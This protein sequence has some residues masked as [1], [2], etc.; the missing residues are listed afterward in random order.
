[1]LRNRKERR[2]G[3]GKGEEG[4]G[5][6]GR[7]SEGR[8]EWRGREEG[9]GNMGSK[10]GSWEGTGKEGVGWGRRKGKNQVMEM[11]RGCVPTSLLIASRNSVKT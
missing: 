6:G 5:E 10:G 9:R 4:R 7:R 3:G 8:R 1:M 2:R 11:V